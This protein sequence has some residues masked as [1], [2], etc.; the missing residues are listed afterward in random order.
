MKKGLDL[1]KEYGVVLEGGG[2]KGAYQ[3]GVWQ[4]LR[5]YNVKIKGI[6]G[7]SV[8]ALNGALI[9]MGDFE[10]AKR[11]WE[12]IS[13]SQVMDVDDNQMEKLIQGKLKGQ[14][15]SDI[16][17]EGV[18]VFKTGG[19]DVTPLEQLI[20]QEIDEE[21]I[22]DSSVELLL[23]T[24]SIT[25][26]K[27]MTVS[28]AE[29]ERGYLKDYLL[30]SARLPFFKLK[31]IQGKKYLDGGVFNNVPI[32][33]LIEK[34][35]ED[36]LVVRIFGIGLEKKV[37]IP[38]TVNVTTIAP[39]VELGNLLEFNHKKSKRNMKIGY[40]DGLRCICGLE[41]K[42]YYLQCEREER[43]YFKEL[44]DIKEPVQ[45][46]WIA[47]CKLEVT[48]ESLYCRKMFEIVYPVLAAEWNLEKNWTYQNLYIAMLEYGARYFR[49][50]KYNIYTEEELLTLV[51]ESWDIKEGDIGEFTELV[52]RTLLN[53]LDLTK[54]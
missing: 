51:K 7:V 2:A 1:T 14:D 20:I 25:N 39:Q 40:Y 5:E 13:Y 33:M 43:D 53:K 18:K 31:R 16:T 4:A 50:P 44:V 34:G 19:I 54:I 26:L 21:K 48:E 15:L 36:I 8:G 42:N 49:I 9:A 11:I 23:G 35:Y 29:V 6:A 38:H 3:I 52:I 22:R 30:A 10:K 27:E 46:D 41:G 28:I 24:F 12:N 17:K 47:W 45:R 37:K 32:D